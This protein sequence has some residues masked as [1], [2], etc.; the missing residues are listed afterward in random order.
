MKRK[1]ADSPTSASYYIGPGWAP[2]KMPDG[3]L[4]LIHTPETATFGCA[5]IFISM[6]KPKKKR[7]Q[8]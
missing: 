7:A 8:K 3:T 1:K 2:L 5:R 4:M 6:D